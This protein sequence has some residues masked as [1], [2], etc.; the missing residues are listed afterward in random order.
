[1]EKKGAREERGRRRRKRRRKAKKG[2]GTFKKGFKI[3]IDEVEPLG[4]FN[5]KEVIFG[6]KGERRS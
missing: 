5:N 2:A 4:F 6:L 1:M 3:V